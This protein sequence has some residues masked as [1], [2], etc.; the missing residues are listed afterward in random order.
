MGERIDIAAADGHRL[1]AYLATPHG[2]AR[3]GLVVIQTAFGVDDYLR[4]VCESYARDGYVAIAPALYD[5]QRRD[6]V[7]EHTPDGAAGAQDLR[8][9]LDWED[10]LRDV[11]AARARVAGAGKTGI[12]GF[13]VG[14]SVVWLAAHALNF[15]AA[16]SYYGKDVVDFLDRP[17]KC[18]TILH[19]GDQDRLIPVSDV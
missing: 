1:S 10:V 14:G 16:A 6:A 12:V 13:C 11:E 4:G 15:A 9:G 5:R 18:P 17:P 3:G 19:F 8:R 2:A 7:F